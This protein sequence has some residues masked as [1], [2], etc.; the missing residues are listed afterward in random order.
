MEAVRRFVDKVTSTN[1]VDARLVANFDQV[2]SVRYEPPKRVYHKDQDDF[3][4][5]TTPCPKRSFQKIIDGLENYMG[6]PDGCRQFP[7]PQKKVCQQVSLNAAGN[8]NPV[9]YARNA[10][11]CTTLSWRDGDL[12]RAWITISPG[13][14]S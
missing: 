13:S 9:D 4:K 3:G 5:L 6:V 12:G 1:V 7:K 14:M 8:M 10:R 2:W 11:T